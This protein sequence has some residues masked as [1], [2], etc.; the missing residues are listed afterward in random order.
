MPIAARLSIASV[1]ATLREKRVR[2]FILVTFLAFL[3]PLS[4]RAEPSIDQLID[5]LNG[6]S[7]D[8]E[9]EPVKL[10][11]LVYSPGPLMSGSTAKS[12]RDCECRGWAARG[13]AE[14]KTEAGPAI[15]ALIKYIKNGPSDF[16]DGRKCSQC[17]SSVIS[18]AG[19]I[20][21]P[22]F[23]PALISYL[24]SPAG[25]YARFGMDWGRASGIL[26][27]IE[28]LGSFGPAACGAAPALKKYLT[29]QRLEHN[30][31]V[32]MRR[33]ALIRALR[34]VGDKDSIDLLD[35]ELLR[36]KTITSA[37]SGDKLNGLPGGTAN[38]AAIINTAIDSLLLWAKED[39]ELVRPK[40][41]LLHSM[42]QLCRNEIPAWLEQQRKNNALPVAQIETDRGHIQGI[43]SR[44]VFLLA[45]LGDPEILPFL[46]EIFSTEISRDEDPA[47]IADN[48]GDK[49]DS[50][51]PE[52]VRVAGDLQFRDEPLTVTIDG[53]KNTRANNIIDYLVRRATPKSIAGVEEIKNNPHLENHAKQ[54]LEKLKKDPA[55]Q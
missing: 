37:F 2:P 25:D 43:H 50:I 51:I 14:R 39:P 33:P 34:A 9:M 10:D 35:D 24:E 4:A 32:D 42:L 20:H 40:I 52:F 13:L 23:V 41:P 8:F 6:K 30:S 18:A 38:I 28:T 17:L 53:T 45:Y 55:P 15:P 44:M 22:A 1:L 48:Y 5:Q 36:L 7:C 16:N 29:K 47:K 26:P 31:D 27:A 12:V 21:D 19:T 54:A 49:I 46:P 11:C 3:L